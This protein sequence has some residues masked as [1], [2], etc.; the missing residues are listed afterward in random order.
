M[1]VTVNDTMQISYSPLNYIYNVYNDAESSDTL[2]A[3]VQQL[4]DYHLAAKAYTA[5]H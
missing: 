4:Y 1:T 2:K 5:L 3:M